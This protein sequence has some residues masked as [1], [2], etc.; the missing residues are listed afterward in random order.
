[1]KVHNKGKFIGGIFIILLSLIPFSYINHAE[2]FK[3]E[4][5]YSI[6]GTIKKINKTTGK[7]GNDQTGWSIKLVESNKIV[8]ITGEYYNAINKT[9]FKDLVKP[10][11]KVKVFMLKSEFH[12]LFKKIETFF[13]PDK[14]LD[15]TSL[16]VSGVEVLN[17]FSIRNRISR[18]FM[19]NLLFGLAAVVYGIFLIYHS[20]K[21]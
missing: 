15:A 8:T 9:E 16:E 20:Y 3:K 7:Y 14:F 11:A 17:L 6:E 10:G 21:Q 2:K 1:M 18:L 19:Q 13:S 12:G 5:F 4:N